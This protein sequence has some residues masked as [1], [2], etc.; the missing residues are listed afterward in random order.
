MVS[1]EDS[2]IVWDRGEMLSLKKLQ[3]FDNFVGG[4][5]LTCS[6]R[7][8]EGLTSSGIIGITTRVESFPIWLIIL[9]TVIRLLVVFV[10]I[11]CVI[12]KKIVQKLL[13]R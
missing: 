3:Q 8:L 9:V 2:V 7:Y 10:G 13:Y 5:L 6:N 11:L 12:K 1:E 4:A